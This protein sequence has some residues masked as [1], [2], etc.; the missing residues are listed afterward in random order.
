MN[1]LIWGTCNTNTA[2][3]QCQ[4]N[5]GSFANSIQVQCSTEIKQ[6]NALVLS[7]LTGTYEFTHRYLHPVAQTSS[8]LLTLFLFRYATQPC[9]LSP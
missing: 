6:Q 5:I 7:T 1:S 2:Y 4:S 3:S 9:K 8:C